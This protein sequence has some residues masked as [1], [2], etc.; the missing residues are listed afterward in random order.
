MA[1]LGV[2]PAFVAVILLFLLPPGPDM[3]YM[4][5]VGLDAGRMAAVKAILGIGTGMTVYATAVVVG[6][7]RFAAAHSL[8]LESV[9]VLGAL[10][11][12][13]LAYT[14]WRSARRSL[15]DP[16]RVATERPY[17]RGVLVALTNPKLILFFIAV[18][19]QFLGT[20]DR[21]FVVVVAQATENAVGHVLGDSLVWHTLTV[22]VL[23]PR[24]HRHAGR[25]G[26]RAAS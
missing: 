22:M 26:C 6:L 16:G 8:L 2:L 19:P 13:W 12:L 10:Y 17:E 5:A 4:L 18:L 11:L 15:G 20:A 14:T 25:S 7:G 9:K 3:A 21:R 1:D 23:V 24:A